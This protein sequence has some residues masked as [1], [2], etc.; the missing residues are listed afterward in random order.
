MQAKAAALAAAPPLA[1]LASAEACRIAN[2]DIV[3]VNCGTAPAP[4]LGPVVEDTALG[5]TT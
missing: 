4:A 2:F 3:A 1:D 5:A